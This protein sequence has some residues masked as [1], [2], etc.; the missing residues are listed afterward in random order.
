MLRAITSMAREMDV[1][2]IAQGVES[3]KEWSYLTSI[4]PTTNVRGYFYSEPVSAERAM[5]LLSDGLI[6]HS[7]DLRPSKSR[8]FSR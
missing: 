6:R 2:V 3:E 4:S 8:K 5:H 1:E 7:I